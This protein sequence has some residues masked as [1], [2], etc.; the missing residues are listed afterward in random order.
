MTE[1]FAMGQ[2][3]RSEPCRP[4]GKVARFSI[5]RMHSILKQFIGDLMDQEIF[6]ILVD[7]GH[8]FVMALV[9]HT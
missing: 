4:E 8:P 2:G 7:H 5:A 3:K 9:P 1:L 6:F